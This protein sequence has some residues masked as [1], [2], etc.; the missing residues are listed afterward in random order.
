MNKFLKAVS[1]LSLMLIAAVPAKAAV[2]YTVTDLGEFSPKAINNQGE[3]VGQISPNHA[4]LF[5]KM[6]S[7]QI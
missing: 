5:G 1:I 4:A 2:E 6:G 3:I 7:L